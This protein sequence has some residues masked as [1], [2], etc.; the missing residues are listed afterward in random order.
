MP[1]NTG[2]NVVLRSWIAAALLLP[3]YA[4]P[5]ADPVPAL[6]EDRRRT[7]VCLIF[8]ADPQNQAPLAHHAGLG[9]ADRAACTQRYQEARKKWAAWLLPYRRTPDLP[10]PLRAS[11]EG[12]PS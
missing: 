5:E 7:L 12:A 4:S 9:E 8:G 2:S 1:R 10:V 11:P 3:G 6:N